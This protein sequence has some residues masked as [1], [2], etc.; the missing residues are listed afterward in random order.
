MTGRHPNRSGVLSRNYALRPE[1]ISL[2]A[3]LRRA[4]YRTGHFGKWHLGPVKAASP[5][6]PGAFGFGTYLSSDRAFNM[7]DV[8]SR[9]GAS[10]IK[11]KG[12]GSEIIVYEAVRFMREA[13]S[14]GEPFF[15][16]I[17]F[18]SPHQPYEGLSQD[19][20][21]YGLF[22]DLAKRY[23]EITAMDRAI[24]F[25]RRVL[26]EMKVAN[27]TIVWFCSDNGPPRHVEENGGLRGS[28]GSL[29]EG[30]VRVPG[31]VEWP[32][33]IERGRV[34]ATPAVTTDIYPTILELA[35]IDPPARPLDG[36]SLK[37]LLA[38]EEFARPAI[39]FWVYPTA[40]EH[41]NASWLSETQLRGEPYV[42][43]RRNP[44][45]FYNFHH[46]ETKLD[47]FSGPAVWLDETW[48]LLAL[49]SE[50]VSSEP[51]GA[52]QRFEL[53][54]LAADSGEQRDL[55]GRHP[56]TVARM[57]RELRQWQRSVEHSLSGAD[58]T[59]TSRQ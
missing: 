44:A 17:W 58:Y 54:D 43:S 6:N 31:V 24:G 2:A 19:L 1:E 40:G 16:A 49:D 23:A 51:A 14:A 28:K 30:G 37:P 38:G 11:F 48:K 26:R 8:L 22:G 33:V 32:G 47:G 35:G 29:Y 7:N 12:E 27:E 5:V 42:R 15:V 55:A 36:V 20:M 52:E 4:G 59:A 21:R 25:V 57:Q 53:Y 34:V 9:N 13:H 50:P 56:D 46:P 45:R 18:G 3:L 41:G 10:P 39:G